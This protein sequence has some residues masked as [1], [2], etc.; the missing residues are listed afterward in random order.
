MT[1]PMTAVLLIAL[2]P[3]LAC[4][5]EVRPPGPLPA[6]PPQALAAEPAAAVVTSA[7]ENMFRR[8][9]ADA[10]VVSQA[11]LGTN[12]RLVQKERNA[13][14][15][16]W[17]E[18]E[19]PDTYRGWIIASALRV[20]GPGDRPYASAGKVF[21]VSSLLANTYRE[22]SATRHKPVKVAPISAVLEVVGEKDERWLEVRLPCGTN[23]WIQRG[24]GDIREAPWTW[25][26]RP[27]EEI[28][29]LSRRFIGLTYTWG[30]TSPYGFDCSGFVQLV[31]KMSGIALLRDARL[32]FV[33]PELDTV[34][35]GEERAGD[36]VYFGRAADRITHVG[37]MIDGEHFI[38][39]KPSGT[40]GV[41]I[42]RLKDDNWQRIYQGARRLR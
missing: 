20:L 7:V 1:K 5:G 9:S 40:P 30:G 21:V 29:A 36:L 24:E 31:H 2:S 25:P 41:Q 11:I 8:S 37:L 23:A 12:V 18:V 28:V 13:A 42:D 39:A 22:D 27:V 3:V 6:G 4:A 26:R 15:E 16:D 38:N 17:Y 10:D 34:A 35:K 33:Q 32:Q 19:T 14:G